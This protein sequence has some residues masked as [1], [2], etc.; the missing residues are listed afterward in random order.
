MKRPCYGC[1]NRKVGCHSVCDAYL[2][3]ETENKKQ[4]DERF[5]RTSALTNP[6]LREAGTEKLRKRAGY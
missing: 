1:L 4:R 2:K 6:V 5:T 3:F